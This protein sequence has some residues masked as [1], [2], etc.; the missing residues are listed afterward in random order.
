MSDA[1]HVHGA[2]CACHRPPRSRTWWASVLPAVACAAC[3]ACMALWKPLLSVVGVSL[4]LS[5]GQHEA[6]LFASL[7]V[8]LVVGAWD[9]WRTALKTP[10]ALTVVGAALMVASHLGGDVPSLEWAGM[11]VMVSSVFARGVLRARL[12]AAAV[13]S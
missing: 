1:S 10:F 13:A 8:A 4:A 5:D 7:A 12:R 6:L 11:A 2:H 3:P 9:L